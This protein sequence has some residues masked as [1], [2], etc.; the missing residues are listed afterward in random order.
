M[1]IIQSN[2]YSYHRLNF[3]AIYVVLEENKQ[4]I[5]TNF[6]DSFVLKTIIST[7]S[8]IQGDFY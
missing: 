8:P 1:K 5:F 4:F 6:F 7:N 3:M 2:A